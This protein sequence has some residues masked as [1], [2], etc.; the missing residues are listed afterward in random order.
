ME[1]ASRSMEVAASV[2]VVAGQV[3]TIS[4]F[5]CGGVHGA[6]LAALHQV[7][8]DEDGGI[9]ALRNRGDTS[10]G[11]E[12]WGKRQMFLSTPAASMTFCFGLSCKWTLFISFK[13]SLTCLQAEGGAWLTLTFAIFRSNTEV[14]KHAAG[15]VCHLARGVGGRGAVG[16]FAPST[17]SRHSVAVRSWSGIP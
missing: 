3:G 1:V 12:G 11:A 8:Q 13:K 7:P 5:C 9:V 17:H 2:G 15:Q 10:E 16:G 14:I 4:G 6:S